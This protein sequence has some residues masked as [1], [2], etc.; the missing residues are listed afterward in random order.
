MYEGDELN[1]ERGGTFDRPGAILSSSPDEQQTA[2]PAAKPNKLVGGQSRF[3]PRNDAR[4]TSIQE[5]ATTINTSNRSGRLLNGRLLIFAGIGVIAVLI[6]VIVVV[7]LTRGGGPSVVADDGSVA[8]TANAK[9]IFDKNAPVP[10]LLSGTGYGYINPNENKWTIEPKYSKAEQFHGNYAKVAMNEKILIIDR[11]GETILKLSQDSDVRYE[12]NDNVWVIDYDVYNSAM[13]KM[14]PDGSKASYL[15]YGYAFIIPANEDKNSSF[16]TGI[17]YLINVGTGEKSYECNAIGC[18]I[19][20]TK[21]ATDDIIYIAVY[22]SGKGVKIYSLKDKNEIYSSPA[23]NSMTKLFNG[24]FVEKDIVE[25]KII[26]YLTIDN[27]AVEKTRQRPNIAPDKSISGARE[28]YATQCS[29]GYNITGVIDDCSIKAY[30]ELPSLVYSW[31][32]ENNKKP[33]VILKEDGIHL[34]DM[35]GQ[36]DIKK[37]DKSYSFETF[38]DSVFVKLYLDSGEK[39]MCN[40]LEPNKDCMTIDGKT[41]NVYATY[42]T[43]DRK[44]YSYNLTEVYNAT[45]E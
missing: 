28:Y 22:E 30:W 16:K 37:Y 10:F 11:K 18:S 15:D 21:G 31:Y 43:V 2:L 6:I 38:D 20:I 42:F 5:Y 32:S 36:K 34:F 35:Q 24:V 44:T 33:V 17:P 8:G 29:G 41:I 4:R 7:L 23:T 25:K 9:I 13:K 26:N 39:R 19:T 14:N 27:N 45:T 3:Q 40:I 1:R 12:I